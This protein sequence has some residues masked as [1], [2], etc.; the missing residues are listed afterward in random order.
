LALIGLIVT[1]IREI[2]QHFARI[3]ALVRD[4]K[5][6]PRRPGPRRPQAEPKPG[7]PGKLPQKFGWLLVA[8]Q[9]G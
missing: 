8:R 3:A 1:R 5:Y 2:K 4:G 7:P 6:L 9:S